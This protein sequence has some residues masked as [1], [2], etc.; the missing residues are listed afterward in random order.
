MWTA[1]VVLSMAVD[2]ASIERAVLA[3]AQQRLQLDAA[4]FRVVQ[5]ESVTWR[6]GSLGCPEP[7][8]LYAQMLVKGW[9]IRVEAGEARL[10]YHA[11]T[12]GRWLYCPADRITDP[13]PDASK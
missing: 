7:G 11:A 6:D 3:D 12:N 9:R 2:L 8:R 5:S 10:E 13:L 1:A 4:R